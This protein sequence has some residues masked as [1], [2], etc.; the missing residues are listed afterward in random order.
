MSKPVSLIIHVWV[1]KRNGEHYV[2]CDHSTP[3]GGLFGM[4]ILFT[5]NVVELNNVWIIF[6]VICNIR[7]IGKKYMSRS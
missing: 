7:K 6:V 1:R 5:E 4:K 2:R 3:G